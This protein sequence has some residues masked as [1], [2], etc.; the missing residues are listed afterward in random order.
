MAE[1]A[2]EATGIEDLEVV[3]DRGYFRSA[4]ILECEQA[5]IT[6]YVP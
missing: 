2:R 6:P 1:R 5:G 3:A 4:E